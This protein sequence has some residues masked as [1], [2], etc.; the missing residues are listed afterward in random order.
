MT[1]VVDEQYR[2]V[3]R[4][5]EA[6]HDIHCHFAADLTY[7][8]G[9]VSRDTGVEVDWPPDPPPEEGDLSDD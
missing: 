1:G 9:T 3:T 5:M 2:R 6:M 7:A 8:L 4:Y